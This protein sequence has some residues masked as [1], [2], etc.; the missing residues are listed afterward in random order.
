MSLNTSAITAAIASI[1]VTAYGSTDAITIRDVD[2]ID[3]HVEQRDCPIMFPAPGEWKGGAN[4]SPDEETTFGT[5]STRMWVVHQVFKYVFIQSPV[6][7]GRD[8]NDYYKAAS[9]NADGLWEALTQVNV[10]AI[11]VESVNMTP[12]GIISD[13]VGGKFVGCFFNI[14]FRERINA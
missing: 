8:I 5:F 6:G 12:I 7:A 9:T 14:A 4:G 3:P 13:P 1:S 2:T 11:D 10:A